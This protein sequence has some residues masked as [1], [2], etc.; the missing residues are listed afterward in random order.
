M[1][2]NTLLSICIGE[3]NMTLLLYKYTPLN[4]EAILLKE[5]FMLF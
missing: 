1:R 2:L 5:V 4:N 3:T